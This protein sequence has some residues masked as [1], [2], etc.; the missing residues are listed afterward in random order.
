MRP[1]RFAALEATIRV[2]TSVRG[3]KARTRAPERSHG[4]SRTGR[5]P[6]PPCPCRRAPAPKV[7]PLDGSRWGPRGT[8]RVGRPPKAR[9]FDPPS[10]PQIERAAPSTVG[11]NPETAETAGSRPLG[12]SAP[13][14][15]HHNGAR[16]RVAT[17]VAGVDGELAG[18]GPKPPPRPTDRSQGSASAAS[19]GR[20]GYSPQTPNSIPSKPLH[21]PPSPHGLSAS[22]ACQH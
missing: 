9:A 14:T 13:G 21:M 20:D 2:Y 10:G 12:R 19:K 4:K 17:A 22:Q 18:A 1:A 11:P 7:E 8:R 16:G 5:P 6:A 3:K 15:S